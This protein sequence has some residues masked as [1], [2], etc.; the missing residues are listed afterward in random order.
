MKTA[1]LIVCLIGM[2]C[3]LSNSISSESH[4]KSISDS[5]SESSSSEEVSITPSLN[6]TTAG[7]DITTEEYAARG[8]SLRRRRAAVR[9]TTSSESHSASLSDSHSD[10]SS[11]EVHIAPTADGT[12]AGQIR[13]DSL[14]KR[15][16]AGQNVH[17]SSSQQTDE[18]VTTESTSTQSRT[19]ESS[20]EDSHEH[21]TKLK[22]LHSI[23]GTT[24]VP[25]TSE[26]SSEE[27]TMNTPIFQP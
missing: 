22:L 6:L 24:A 27:R 18:S 25:D 17:S 20:E 9:D 10:S 14:R 2:T 21:R 26:E 8:D 7:Q 12:T 19:S 3:A 5:H 13:G 15:R 1:V 23:L 16:A 11:E 4:S